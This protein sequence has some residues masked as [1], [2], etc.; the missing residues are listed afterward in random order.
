MYIGFQPGIASDEVY[1][2][3]ENVQHAGVNKCRYKA[4]SSIGTV[5]G[6]ARIPANEE[7]LKNV[8]ANVGPVAFAMNS[9]PESFLYYSSGIYD[10]ATCTPG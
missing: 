5:T 2:Y 6:Y 3:E 1:P 8:I 10:D 4:S 7:I 9:A